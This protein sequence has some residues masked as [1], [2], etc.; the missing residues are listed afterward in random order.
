MPTTQPNAARRYARLT[1]DPRRLAAVR[2][3][4]LP[5]GRGPRDRFEQL[6][7]VA[8]RLLDAPVAI[9]SLVDAERDVWVGLTGVPP[10]LAAAGGTTMRPSFC[11]A[12]I[13]STRSALAIRDA[14]TSSV[15]AEFPSVRALGVGACLGV[16]LITRN[17]HALGTCCVYDMKPRD[18][19]PQDIETL[20]AFGVGAVAEMER[21]AALST[22][23]EISDAVVR[24]LAAAVARHF[25]A[26]AGPLPT[27]GSVDLAVTA[28]DIWRLLQIVAGEEAS[29]TLD[30]AD[31]MS[32][33]AVDHARMV[34]LLVTLVTGARQALNGRGWIQI[35][36]ESGDMNTVRMTIRAVNANAPLGVPLARSAIVAADQLLGVCGGQ[37]A[38][39]DDTR[40]VALLRTA[41][42]G[43]DRLE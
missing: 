14:R 30:F 41:E 39:H 7:A 36:G 18:W 1:S 26:L 43:G 12:I 11:Q 3:T 2:A 19:T 16:P 37:V 23:D 15:F 32:P 31:G 17:G 8:A 20:S 24:Y 38:T 40:A 29:V 13:A 34:R 10:T 22:G 33:V 5:E 9:I 4:G 35:A 42:R 27:G 25:S 21:L 6:A 28:H